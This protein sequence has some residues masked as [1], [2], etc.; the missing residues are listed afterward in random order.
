VAYE[1]DDLPAQEDGIR[2]FMID[3]HW[4]PWLDDGYPPFGLADGRN[5]PVYVRGTECQ[6]SFDLAR[7][8]LAI[9][10]KPGGGTLLDSLHSATPLVLLEPFGAHEAC[11]AGLWERLGFGISL[12]RWREGDFAPAILEEL[13]DTLLRAAP[14]IPDYARMLAE[15]VS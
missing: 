11:N 12:D 6:G 15:E 13:H 10:S 2:Y 7:S 4:H 3:P 1:A 14:G 5:D 8:A 9:V